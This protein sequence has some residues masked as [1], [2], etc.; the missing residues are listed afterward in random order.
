[1]VEKNLSVNR[2]V[3]RD[4]KTIALAHPS[5][6]LWI[7]TEM[8]HLDWYAK[9]HKQKVLNYVS[10]LNDSSFNLPPKTIM[11]TVLAKEDTAKL[12]NYTLKQHIDSSWSY[13]DTWFVYLQKN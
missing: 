4:A 7:V 6:A 10:Y 11:L 13:N 1:V 5:H 9:L 12:H 8:Q 2:L 3:M